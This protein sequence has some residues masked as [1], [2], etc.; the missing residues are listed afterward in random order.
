MQN[1]GEASS[2]ISHGELVK[3]LI[4]LEPHGILISNFACKYILALSGTSNNLKFRIGIGNTVDTRSNLQD[5]YTADVY[6]THK[7]SSLKMGI[8]KL[9]HH[10]LAI[11]YFGFHN[12]E[13]KHVKKQYFLTQQKINVDSF[14]NDLKGYITVFI[15]RKSLRR[16]SH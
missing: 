16:G 4:P 14:K 11:I 9:Y 7:S 8:F 13:I 10:N 2:S 12:I 1:G 3:M 6:S 5:G 15:D